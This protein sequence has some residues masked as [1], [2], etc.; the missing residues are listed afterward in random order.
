LAVPA[1]DIING[2]GGVRKLR[3]GLQGTGQRGGVRVIYYWITKDHQVLFLPAYAKNESSD[4]SRDSI[5][6]MREIV[7]DPCLAERRRTWGSKI[8]A[9]KLSPV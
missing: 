7:K 2:S 9:L 1:G 3:W 5:K 6:A 8:S 4:L